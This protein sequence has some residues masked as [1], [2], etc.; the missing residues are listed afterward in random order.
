MERN[1]ETT[2]L[3]LL[4]LQRLATDV[5]EDATRGRGPLQLLPVGGTRLGS[6]TGTPRYVGRPVA[7]LVA[8][9]SFPEVAWLL[10]QGDLPNVEHL[11]DFQSLLSVGAELPDPVRQL[12]SEL[13][14][15]ASDSDVLRI[16]VTALTAFDPQ[17]ED[18]AP[19][20]EFSRATRLLATAP[21]LLGARRGFDPGG[22]GPRDAEDR[23]PLDSFEYAGRVYRELTGEEP[24]PAIE[25]AIDAIL[26]VLAERP[27][28][29]STLAARIVASNG[30]DVYSAVGA[31]IAASDAAVGDRHCGRILRFVERAE[32]VADVGTW[33]A[34]TVDSAGSLPGFDREQDD[35]PRVRILTEI[36]RDVAV[37][38]G[39]ESYESA[40]R[41]VERSAL[42]V[43][44]ARPTLL[45]PIA[46][47]LLHAG[48]EPESFG[49]LLVLARLAGWS[50]HAIEESGLERRL[51]PIW[52]ESTEST[53]YVPLDLRG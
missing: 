21:L 32:A 45:W 5:L 27:G 13:P 48:I 50:A 12:V 9:S 20:S 36:C 37:E 41:G 8:E 14:L 22:T 42:D 33:F 15:H 25:R 40:A 17:L 39:Q 46:R 6:E 16:G 7:H 35:D 53:D 51:A 18:E 29:P 38:V 3:M 11:A 49:S 10:L 4:G 24:S 2:R 47:L 44:G 19:H 52:D 1:P 31:A 23:A 43:H 34:E 28:D 30:G 26:I